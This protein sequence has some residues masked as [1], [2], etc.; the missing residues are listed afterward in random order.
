MER[1]IIVNRIMRRASKFTYTDALSFN[2]KLSIKEYEKLTGNKH[3]Y[4]PDQLEKLTFGELKD[5][6]IQFDI[7]GRSSKELISEILEKQ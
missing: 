1:Y 7:K 5:I 6:A 4:T 3:K 2:P